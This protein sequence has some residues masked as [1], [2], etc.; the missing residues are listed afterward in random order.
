MAQQDSPLFSFVSSGLPEDTF[1]VVRFT[2]MEALSSLYR[3]E[4]LLI[5]RSDSVDF[6]QMLVDPATFRIQ[7]A[8]GEQA[9][10]YHGILE[11]FEQMQKVD[12][13][14]FYQ[15]VL[16]PRLWRLTLTRHNQIFL[17]QTPREIID[18]C[19]KDGGLPDAA[20]ESRIETNRTPWSYAC[21]YNE[22]H[23]HFFSH[24]TERHGYY[25]YFDQRGDAE[26]L[27]VTDTRM[28]HESLQ[29]CPTLD[30]TT[31]SGLDFLE[32]THVVKDFTLQVNPVPYCV[33]LKNSNYETPDLD[34]QAEATVSATGIGEVYSYG[35]N[36][37]TLADGQ[38]LANIRAEELRCRHKRFHASSQVPFITPGYQ[39]TLQGHFR[40][41]FN[42]DYLITE[43][44]HEGG[45]EAYLTSGM[46]LSG[47][48]ERPAYRNRFICIPASEQFRP[49][50][51]TTPPRIHGTLTARI[52]AASSGQ[53]AELDEQGRYKVILPFDLSGKTDG[54]ASTWLRKVE[55]YAGGDHGMHFPLHKGTEVILSFF[56][57]DP[58]RPYILA[59]A[60]N[61]ATPNV[62]NDQSQT[63]CRITTG[64][65][66]KLHFE[67]Q[68]GKQNILL[69]TPTSGSFISLGSS[70]PGDTP[71]GDTPTPTT[72]KWLGMTI[73]T[74]DHLTVDSGQMTSLV[75]GNS[76]TVIG[77][78]DESITMG[79]ENY[80]YL[81]D[82]NSLT[83]GISLSFTLGGTASL[84][85]G[86]S[87]NITLG[88]V[89]NF[90]APDKCDLSP[91]T[92]EM[93][94]EKIRIDGEVNDLKGELNDLIGSHMKL[95]VE[96][97]TVAGK[98]MD[99]AGEVSAI[100]GEV[101]KVAGSVKNLAGE[102]TKL[103]GAST[104]TAG[105]Q[106]A[107]TGGLTTIVGEMN[108]TSATANIL[109][110][111]A[112]RISTEINEIAAI[113]TLM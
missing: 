95:A 40:H 13:F 62:V 7:S 106:Q 69:S 76:T 87:N 5:S 109:T 88:H 25:Y 41:D 17:N 52:D 44:S 98:I 39:F 26:T 90:N 45:Q 97:Q 59:A 38:Q 78:A 58:N 80:V 19:L 83:L 82:L 74:N 70:P 43:A 37:L 48:T 99:L 28:S 65:Q 100:E 53:Y 42:G 94:A 63:Q 103:V 56:D 51:Q 73:K 15:A 20:H 11:Q 18:A 111:E 8:V 67:D 55:P 85:I 31:P 36:F 107:T 9:A 14:A 108:E 34:L 79:S 84:T 101:S 23:F 24:W 29:G 110:G 92:K 22:S 1:Q 49:C 27:I 71:P 10:P 86:S 57:G 33:K 102:T 3:F 91:S 113:M 12:G 72:A 61:P 104:L 64:G 35:E 47:A 30:Y 32:R 4:I 6:E 21:Q 16:V 81:A 68:D 66:N 77:G 54:K 60:P 89:Y 50:R 96:S 75:Q 2:G 105:E 112:S 46:G 93:A